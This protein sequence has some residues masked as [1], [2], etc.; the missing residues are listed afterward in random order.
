MV[1]LLEWVEDMFGDQRPLRIAAIH[2]AP[3]AWFES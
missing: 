1:M 2:A 3:S